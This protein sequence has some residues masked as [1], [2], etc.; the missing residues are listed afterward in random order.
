MWPFKKKV[1][2]VT[3][4]DVVLMREKAL[5]VAKDKEA[6]NTKDLLEYIS[7]KIDGAALSGKTSIHISKQHL[8][9]WYTT[10]TNVLY[11]NVKN[12]FAQY[13]YT[14]RSGMSR[15]YFI[16]IEWGDEANE[17]D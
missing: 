2:A 8:E 7:M 13:G 10:P 16:I 14:V 5:S 17:K 12:A 11:D 4:P 6:K 15:E 1:D 9:M 3:I